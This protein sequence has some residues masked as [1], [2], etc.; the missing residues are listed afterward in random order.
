MTSDQIAAMSYGF[1]AQSMGQMQH[2]AM[3][4]QQA[5]YGMP[6][7]ESLMGG[8]VNRGA[9]I[10]SPLLS[11][12]LGIAGLDPFSMGLR[13]AMWGGARYGMMGAIGM[14]GAAAAGVG[15]PLMAAQYVGGQMMTGMQQQQGLNAQ[16]RSAYTFSSGSTGGRGFSG[17]ELGD[18]GQMLRQMSGQRGPGGEM[19]TFDELGRMA[20]MMG[21]M[22]M[23]EGVRSAKEFND[24]FQQMMKSV[25]EI[26]KAFSTSLE[27][28]QQIMGSMRSSGIFKNQGAVANQIRGYALGGN[29]ATSEI[30]SMMG[31]GSQISRSIGGRGQAGA[32]GGMQTIGQIGLALQTGTLSEQDVYNAT[33]LTGAAGRQAMAT[34]LMQSS[35][36]FLKGGLGRRFLASVAGKGGYLDEGSVEDYMYGNVGT[37]ETMGMAGRNLAKVGR[38]DFI[39]NEGRLRGEALGKFGGLTNIIAMRGWL[40][41]RGFDLTSGQDDRAMIFMQRRLG[42]GNDEAESMLKMARDLPLMM[43]QRDNATE[44]AK[45]NQRL[46]NQR[47]NQGLAGVKKKLESARHDVQNYLQQA[48]AEFYQDGA[49]LLERW[50]NQLTGS[51]FQQVSRDVGPAIRDAMRGGTYGDSLLQSRFGFDRRGSEAQMFE[52]AR[53]GIFGGG[54]S[55]DVNAFK[56]SGDADRFA[57]AGWRVGTGSTAEMRRDL[58]RVQGLSDAYREGEVGGTSY[59]RVGKNIASDLLL[60]VAH[61]GMKGRG[62]DR[63]EGFM[64]ML[65]RSGN[66]EMRVLAE[67]M[68]LQKTDEARMRIMGSVMRGAGLGGFDEGFMNLP[69][70]QAI[71]GSGA[72]ATEADRNQAIGDY[73]LKNAKNASAVSIKEKSGWGKFLGGATKFAAGALGGMFGSIGAFVGNTIGDYFSGKI[74]EGFDGTGTSDVTAKTREAAGRYLM[75]EKGM[76]LARD[77]LSTDT[78]VRDSAMKEIAIR[79]VELQGRL[80]VRADGQMSNIEAGEFEGNRSMLMA[81]DLANLSRK[82]PRGDIPDD[83]KQQVVRRHNAVSWEDVVHRGSAAMGG[84][85]E[86]Q[87]QAQR[88]FLGEVKRSGRARKEAWQVSGIGS[89]DRESWKKLD[90][91]PKLAAKKGEFEWASMNKGQSAGHAYI[92]AMMGS[93]NIMAS[94]EDYDGEEGVRKYR[95]AQA[96]RAKGQAAL[97]SMSVS[98]MR[99]FAKAMREQGA[100]SADVGDVLSQAAI[101]D[102]LIRA[103]GRGRDETEVAAQL[104]LTL[105]SEQ[106]A[107]MKGMTAEKAAGLLATDLSI[108]DKG[109][110]E[111]LTNVLKKAREGKTDRGEGELRTLQISDILAA[112]RKEQQDKQQEQNDPSYRLLSKMSSALEDI[113]G[114]FKNLRVTVANI[115]ELKDAEKEKPGT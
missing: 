6:M 3:I 77:V 4:S 33:G 80:A 67:Q 96:E 61:G 81:A 12:G 2:A 58:L 76:K 113:K 10:G 82:Y 45:F 59:G 101:K 90:I 36:Q 107:A 91:G 103:H 40:E 72:F 112:A 115:G 16:M 71:F 94:I 15:I 39:R 24:K 64:K 51:F 102:K 53:R 18:I 78:E 109:F 9:A 13:G 32:M 23:A 52:N 25:K 5:G 1:Q 8:A 108:T 27:E 84:V 65:E 106:Q 56:S 89:L 70:T 30:T 73:M 105:T 21:R 14:G 87:R 46:D 37:G 42:L 41:Q 54:R 114:S 26:A 60:Q 50:V 93:A 57:A 100:G 97:S 62:A 20:S 68:R 88:Q 85:A 95:L 17:S 69:E 110:R 34:Q 29:L 83:E 22:G 48:G 43:R 44:D 11:A 111:S 98:D 38:A 55:D 92:E 99:K 79:N 31:I 49:N 7:S 74:Q 104:G 66:G 47:S 63:V 19:A 75:S 28:A 35:A 86:E